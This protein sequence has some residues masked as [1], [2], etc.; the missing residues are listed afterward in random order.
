LSPRKRSPEQGISSWLFTRPPS[1]RRHPFHSTLWLRQRRPQRAFGKLRRRAQ[2]LLFSR[3]SFSA[4]IPRARLSEPL[5]VFVRP[6]DET[7][8]ATISMAPWRLG[9]LNWTLSLRPSPKPA[10][11]WFL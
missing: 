4:G 3:R 9:D 7:P 6:K 1:F 11:S 2:G 8:S 5:W 10:C